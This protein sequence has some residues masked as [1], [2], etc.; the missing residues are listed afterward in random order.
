MG[1]VRTKGDDPCQF[2]SPVP[3]IQQALNKYLSFASPFYLK[4]SSKTNKV[5]S[6]K[7]L[8]FILL[9]SFVNITCFQKYWILSSYF[10]SPLI[11]RTSKN[12][13]Q[14]YQS[15]ENHFLMADREYNRCGY[16]ICGIKWF[17][18]TWLMKNCPLLKSAT[19]LCEFFSFNGI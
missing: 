5:M 11:K 9:L 1:F 4:D 10:P 12:K 7:S 16:P 14:Y 8:S 15:K 13:T 18:Q 19:W 3:F 2:P 6:I 17:W